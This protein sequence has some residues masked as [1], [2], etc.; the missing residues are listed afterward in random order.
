MANRKAI[1][2]ELVE[3]EIER[4]SKLPEVKL[5]RR[6]RTLINRRRAVMHDLRTLEKRGKELMAMGIDAEV[7]DLMYQYPPESEG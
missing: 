4:L 6:E 5:A 1:P 3:A 7:L 2:A